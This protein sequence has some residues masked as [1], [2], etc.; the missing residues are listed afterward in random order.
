MRGLVPSSEFLKWP[1]VKHY[2]RNTEYNAKEIEK[3]LKSKRTWMTY[4]FKYPDRG[5]IA[6]NNDDGPT[7]CSHSEAID[8]WV[9]DADLADI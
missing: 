2:Q 8:D 7:L 1:R 6:D 4:C 5:P 3:D 9:V